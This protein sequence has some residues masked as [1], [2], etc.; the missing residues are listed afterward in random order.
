MHNFFSAVLYSINVN[1][2]GFTLSPTRCAVVSSYNGASSGLVGVLNLQ[3]QDS[4][5]DDHDTAKDTAGERDGGKRD[6]RD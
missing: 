3:M 6:E 5:R 2:T 1:I 4:W